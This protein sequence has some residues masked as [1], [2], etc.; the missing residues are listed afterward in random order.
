MS[1]APT[2]EQQRPAH[3]FRKGVSGNPNGRKPGSRNKLAEDFLADLSA[4]WREHGP[5]ALRKCFEEEPA[6]AV[7]IVAG[8]MPRHAEIAVDIDVRT[9][10]TSMLA[11]FRGEG[12]PDKTIAGLMRLLPKT[13]DHA[14]D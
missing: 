1:T 5:E 10:V 12:V 2:V 9:Q 14:D 4:A 3:W 6:K 7:S 13:I 11:E 8:L